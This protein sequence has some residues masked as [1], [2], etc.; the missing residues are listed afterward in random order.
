MLLRLE[1]FYSYTEKTQQKRTKKTKQ[2]KTQEIYLQRTTIYN[3]H[4]GNQQINS[5]GTAY[6]LIC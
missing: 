6:L 1:E 2:N 3:N 4:I 5:S